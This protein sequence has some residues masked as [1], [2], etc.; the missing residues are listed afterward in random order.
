MIRGFAVDRQSKLTKGQILDRYHPKINAPQPLLD[1]INEQ[2]PKGFTQHGEFYYVSDLR[3]HAEYATNL[4]REMPA[5]LVYELIRQAHFPNRP[6]RYESIFAFKDLPD[7]TTF[8]ASAPNPNAPIWELEARD[9]FVVD[10]N[11]VGGD[12]PACVMSSNAHRYWAGLPYEDPS[13]P[14]KW[15]I[16]MV[17]PVRVVKLA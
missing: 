1:H 3:T 6:S 14:P 17:P 15:E 4:D 13:V 12:V 9:G 11:L 7:A 10:M 8:Q 16:L 5:E 2:F